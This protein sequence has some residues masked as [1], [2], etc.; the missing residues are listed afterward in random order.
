MECTRFRENK[1]ETESQEDLQAMKYC[2]RSRE[3]RRSG[4]SFEGGA[5]L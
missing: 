4:I 2:S 1:W 5:A 3:E